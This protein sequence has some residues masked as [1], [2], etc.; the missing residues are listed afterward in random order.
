[1]RVCVIATLFLLS[2]GPLL[3]AETRP[4]AASLFGKVMCG[5][6]GWFAADGDRAGV[7]WKHYGFNREGR[8]SFDMWPDLEGFEADELFDSP[9][10]Y[11]DGST[12]QVF[13]SAHPRTVMRHFEWMR[14]YGIDGAFLQRFGASLRRPAMRDFRDLVQ[15]NV[16]AAS[17]KTGRAWALMYDLSGLK[18]GE[19]QTV[20]MQDW[21]R[22]MKELQITRDPHYLHHEGRPVVAVWGVG[23]KD[24]RAYSLDEC[25]VLLRF[26]RDNPEFGKL[27][28]MVGVPY[29]WRT[30]DR[31]ALNDPKLHEVLEF[32]DIISPWSVGRYSSPERA[33][34]AIAERVPADITWCREHGQLYLPVAFPGFSWR[35]LQHGRGEEAELNAIQRLGGEFLWSQARALTQAGS[36]SVYVAMFDELDEATAIMKTTSRVPV[37]PLGFVTEPEVPSDRYLRVTGEIGRLIRQEIPA[38]TP[39]SEA[40]KAE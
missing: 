21:K 1:M 24:D 6:Q 36:T 9:F 29:G 12:A 26:L 18:E 28:V 27:T 20:I 34:K 2:T 19:I 14:D 7:G 31:D 8:C 17:R 15:D 25:L 5:Y 23:F 33:A 10:Q 4:K 11:E 16:R 35:N 13:S 22:Q 39:L 38:D 37:N 32:A 30:L 40:I 3:Q